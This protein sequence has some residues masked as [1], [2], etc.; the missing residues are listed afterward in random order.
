[1]F[2]V[3]TT[4]GMKSGI[5]NHK[6]TFTESQRQKRC[7]KPL[8][9]FAKIYSLQATTIRNILYE[10]RYCHVKPKRI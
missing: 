4:E 1:M 8:F 5:N 3:S 2:K 10:K 9:P 6:E 7:P